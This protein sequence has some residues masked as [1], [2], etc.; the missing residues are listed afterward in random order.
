MIS[1]NDAKAFC[2]WMSQAT[3]LAA[4]LPQE[5]EWEFACRGSS[6]TTFLWGNDPNDGY[7]WCNAADYASRQLIEGQVFNWNDEYALTAPVGRFRSNSFGLHDVTGNVWE[8]CENWYDKD[9]YA[10]NSVRNP[11]EAGDNESRVLRGGS[12]LSI[13]KES[14][15]A[16]RH[17]DAPDC[18]KLSVGFRVVVAASKAP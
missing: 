5:A 10:S 13:P 1:W 9:S 12:C 18:R 4:R 2:N 11:T 3:G 14:R 17:Y 16:D 6:T 8:W 15:L 7:G